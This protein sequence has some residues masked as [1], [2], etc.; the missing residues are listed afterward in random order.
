M[1][2]HKALAG[3]NL[4]VERYAGVACPA[5]G[6][7]LASGRLDTYRV[8]VVLAEDQPAVCGLH[9]T[10]EPSALDPARDRAEV[11]VSG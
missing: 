2:L 7:T 4:T 9:T 11:V 3:R 6:M 1:A 8:V 10:E 5:R